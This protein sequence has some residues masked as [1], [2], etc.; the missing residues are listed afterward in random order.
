MNILTPILV[1]LGLLWILMLQ[2]DLLSASAAVVCIAV[3]VL[4]KFDY[5]I[6]VAFGIL[7]LVV[8]A[9]FLSDSIISDSF[10]VQS[11]WLFV[12]GICSA[13]MTHSTIVF[14]SSI[15]KGLR[16]VLRIKNEDW[17]QGKNQS[18]SSP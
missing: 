2:N 6:P 3:F 4:F 7:L 1:I 16:K 10:A 17:F 9:V 8:G 13:L 14:N 18:Y 15:Y 5:R 12:I 11:F